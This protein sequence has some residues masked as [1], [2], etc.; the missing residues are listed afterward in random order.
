MSHW[1]EIDNDNVV[2]RVLSCDNDDPAGDEGHSY[3]IN[4]FGGRWI[5]TSYNTL[6]G[7]HLLGGTPLRKNF[8]GIG[9]VYDEDLDAFVWPKPFESWTL[10]INT[11]HWVP[12]VPL[13]PL[14]GIN[15]KWNEDSLQWVVVE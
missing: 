7:E 4:T 5:Q 3:L 10:D 1:A 15:R 12:P 8:A 11:G 14:D 2:V 13:P 6:A 9:M